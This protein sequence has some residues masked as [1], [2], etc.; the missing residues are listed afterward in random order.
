MKW[1]EQ[2]ATGVRRIDE[3]H[4][5]IFKTAEDFRTAL[6]AGEGENTYMLLLD[7]LDLYVRGHFGY[8]ERCMDE[9]RCPAAKRNQQAHSGFLDVLMGYREQYAV[10]GYRPEDARALVDAV[11]QWLD[12]HICHIDVQLKNSVSRQQA[13]TPGVS[14]Q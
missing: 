12:A 13:N 7:F 4:R 5:M 8:E 10:G 14:P 9:Y 3:H 11:D 2:Y 1:T 6:D